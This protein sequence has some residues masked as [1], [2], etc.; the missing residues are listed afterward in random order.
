M[1][2]S[3]STITREFTGQRIQVD[4]SLSFD[5]VRARL[6][7]LL[8]HT[9][10]PEINAIAQSAKSETAYSREVEKRFIGKSGFMLLAEINHGCWIRIFGI[11]RKVLRLILGNPLIAITMIRHDINAALF[12]PMELLL[13]DHC[14][15]N[16]SSLIYVRPSSLIVIDN[17]PDLLAAAKVL[18]DKL[19]ALIMHATNS[20]G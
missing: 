10:I 3:S 18:D 6:A 4:T 13:T 2:A 17:N 19:E 15:G 8:G 7:D 20:K 12:V 1:K 11:H 5:D 16:G 14:D 9:S